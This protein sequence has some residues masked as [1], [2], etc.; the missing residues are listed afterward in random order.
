MTNPTPDLRWIDKHLL[1]IDDSYQRD[2]SESGV[3]RTV[4]GFTWSSYGAISVALRPD[5]TYRVVDGQHRVAAAMQ[6]PQIVEL[7]CVVHRLDTTQAEAQSFLDINAKARGVSMLYKFKAA[8]VAQDP[9]AL[10]VQDALDRYGVTLEKHPRHIGQ[11]KCAGFLWSLARQDVKRLERV[12]SVAVDT[13]HDSPLT[14]AIMRGLLYLDQN[15]SGGLDNALLRERL[16]KAGG[17]RLDLA[18]RRARLADSYNS[19]AGAVFGRAF[20]DLINRGCRNRIG[21]VGR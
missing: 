21:L 17:L 20:L 11:T 15:V 2:I 7:P 6:L 14:D 10:A 9:A 3:D 13:C 4:R 8:L 5:G 19:D 1:S 18:G 16:R 12:L